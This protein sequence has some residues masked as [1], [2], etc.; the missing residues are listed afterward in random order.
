MN[1]EGIGIPSP[2]VSNTLLAWSSFFGQEDL[3][4]EVSELAADGLDGEWTTDMMEV[5]LEGK[6]WRVAGVAT[7]YSMPSWH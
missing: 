2:S 3:L 7:Q 6:A 1:A 5:I 4:T